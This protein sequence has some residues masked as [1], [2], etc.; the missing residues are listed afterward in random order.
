MEYCLEMKAILYFYLISF[1]IILSLQLLFLAHN[2]SSDLKVSKSSSL[3][4]VSSTSFV[5]LLSKRSVYV[6]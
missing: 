1:L 2:I 6:Q 5:Y 4:S 3:S